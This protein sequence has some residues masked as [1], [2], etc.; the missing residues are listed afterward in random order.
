[1]LCASAVIKKISGVM[2]M[3]HRP[4]I[5]VIHY[6]NSI[7]SSYFV[8]WK[9]S[10]Y[11]GTIMLPFVSASKSL[12]FSPTVV[13]CFS[14]IFFSHIHSCLLSFM[15]MVSF[16]FTDLLPFWRHCNRWWAQVVFTREGGIQGV[17]MSHV[18]V[19]EMIWDHGHC[20]PCVLGQSWCPFHAHAY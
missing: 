1:M 13:C 17:T 10:F 9:C 12:F 11:I 5:V 20:Y 15:V 6:Y 7:V 18:W 8:W 4:L 3:C 2:A 16:L 19:A 14:L